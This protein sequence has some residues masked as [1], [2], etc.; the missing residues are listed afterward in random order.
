MKTPSAL[1][2][3]FLLGLF[4]ATAVGQTPKPGNATDTATK[5]DRA[6]I[7][8]MT[9]ESFQQ[10]VQAMGFQCTRDKDNAGKEDAFFTFRAEGYKVAAFAHDPSFLQLY[11]AFSDVQPTLATVNEWNQN[12][13]LSRAYV[14]K[15]G[16]AVLEN[17]LFLTGGVTRDN[18][19]N[20]V[21]NFRD[22]VARWARFV[23]DRKK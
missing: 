10:I 4:S 3:V 18:V 13:S 8:S 17:D 23:L 6:I 19:E 15:D 22:S 7:T 12:N 20:F 1:S 2:A 5:T 9:S 21:K 14:D 16:N 11:N